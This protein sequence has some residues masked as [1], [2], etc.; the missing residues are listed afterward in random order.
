M[1]VKVLKNELN[2]S[3][4]NYQTSTQQ[5]RDNYA[6][7]IEE[8]KK[9]LNEKTDEKSRL[10]ISLQEFTTKDV[11]NKLRVQTLEDLLQRFESGVSKLE[12]DGKKDNVLVEQVERLEQQLV[13]VRCWY[14][15]L[16]LVYIIF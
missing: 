14:L 15:V 7:Q 13:Q 8:L 3:S 4:K 16:M 2:I 6:K 1:N 11:N 12:T 10:E 9:Q 5:Q